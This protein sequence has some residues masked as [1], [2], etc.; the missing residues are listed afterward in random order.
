MELSLFAN[1]SKPDIEMPEQQEIIYSSR[2][3][4]V[5]GRANLKLSFPG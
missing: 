3:A 5:D 4:E 2:Q 1:Y